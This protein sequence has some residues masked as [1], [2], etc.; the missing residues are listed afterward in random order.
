MD[1]CPSA[2]GELRRTGLAAVGIR[3]CTAGTDRNHQQRQLAVVLLVTLPCEVLLPSPGH[4]ETCC[5]GKEQEPSWELRNVCET[6]L[7]GDGTWGWGS[8]QPCSS[9]SSAGHPQE[10]AE[11]GLS[12]AGR[13]S[14]AAEVCFRTAKK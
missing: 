7:D 13:V 2:C 5:P 6:P 8:R 3:V 1:W 11:R 10:R 9:W 12:A 14:R 4:A